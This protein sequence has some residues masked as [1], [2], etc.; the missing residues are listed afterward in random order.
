MYV[1][2]VYDVEE[3]RVTK[4]FNLCKKYL[5]WKQRS[6]FEGKISEDKLKKLIEEI[7][8]IRNK[9]DYVVIYIL[10]NKNNLKAI[11][12]GKKELDPFIIS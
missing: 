8:E 7:N 9:E 5:L 12:I 11:E 3:S 2:L 6:V 4:F 1:I 10:P